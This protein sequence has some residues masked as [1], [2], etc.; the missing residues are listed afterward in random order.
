METLEE[1]EK[2]QQMQEFKERVPFITKYCDRC[3]MLLEV[4]WVNTHFKRDSGCPDGNL[5]LK[6][7]N[8][9]WYHF[10]FGHTRYDADMNG[11]E[12]FEGY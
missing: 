1:F 3:G 4:K 10:G 11:R 12:I 2:F 7:S 9:R 5:L 8:W 6:C